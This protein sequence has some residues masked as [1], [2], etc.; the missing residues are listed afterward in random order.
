MQAPCSHCGTLH[1]LNDAQAGGHPR[2][3]FRCSRCGKNTIVRTRGVDSTHGVDSKQVLSPLPDFA[4]GGGG[5]GIAALLGVNAQGFYLPANKVISLSVIAG[6]A[7]GQ[8]QSLEKPVVILGRSDSDFTIGDPNISRQHCAVEVRGDAV[9]L[10]DLDSTNGTFV[11]LE[12][13]RAA[14][15]RHLSEF[16]MGLTVVLVTITPKLSSPF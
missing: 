11:G 4:R 9:R 16:R 8:A 7:K 10:R 1:A 2:V 14:E 6:P 12:R 15:L 5:P 13:V 3:Q